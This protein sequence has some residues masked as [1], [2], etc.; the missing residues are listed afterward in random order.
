MDLTLEKVLQFVVNK[1]LGLG[2]ALAVCLRLL[3]S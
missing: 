2:L 1:L 3:F